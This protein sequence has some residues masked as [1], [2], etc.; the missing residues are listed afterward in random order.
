MKRFAELYTALDETTKTNA[1][2]TALADYLRKL[3][4]P[5]GCSTSPTW[6]WATSAKQSP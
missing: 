5:C 3:P 6:L 1:K 4:S 2:I